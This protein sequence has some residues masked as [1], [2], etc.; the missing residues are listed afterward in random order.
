MIESASRSIVLFLFAVLAGCG[1][2]G[3]Q[4]APVHGQIK[5]NGQPL[6]T[7]DVVFQPEGEQRPSMGRTDAEGRYELAYKRGE[8]GALVGKHTVKIT[9][10]REMVKHPPI[11]AAR[12]N[13]QSELH[14]EVKPGQ[15][16]LNFDVAEESREKAD[17]K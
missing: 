14:C 16:E 11:I 7:A 15:N 12:F 10:S 4:V 2:S 17:N 3:V 9:V 13:T 5:L 8:A 6:A 1:T